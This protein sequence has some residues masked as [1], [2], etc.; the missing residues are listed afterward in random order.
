MNSFFSV[1]QWF[2]LVWHGRFA[3]LLI[4]LGVVV[5]SWVSETEATSAW[6]GTAA[7]RAL[8]LIGMPFAAARQVLFDSY[9]HVVLRERLSQPVTLVEID[10][11]SLK[12]IGQWPWPRNQLAVLIDMIAAQKPLAIGLDFY[13]P[14]LD[15]TSPGRV[16]D[17]L[18][19][20]H[21][22]LARRLRQLPSHEA[23]LVQSLKAA[24]T[25]LG[26]AGLDQETPI[27]RSG[28]RAVP[29]RV[30]GGD[31]LPYL[32][33][34]PWVLAS[35]PEL[36]AAARGQALLSIDAG[37]TVIRRMPLVMAVNSQVLPS[38]ALEMLRVATAEP[39]LQ[40]TVDAHG[41]NSITV[42]DLRIPTQAR[43]D[44]WLHFARR[45]DDDLARQVSAAAVMQGRLPAD[46]LL[47]KLVLVGLTGAGLNDK[48]FTP[49]GQ[50]VPGIELQA[51]LLETAL[52][53]RFLLRPWWLKG[54][55]MGL[56]VIIGLLMVWLIPGQRRA[57]SSA[58]MTRLRQAPGWLFLAGCMAWLLTG[59][60][61]F[62]HWGWLMDASA[63]LL[64]YA[65]VLPSLMFSVMLKT[66]HDNQRLAVIQQQLREDAARVTGEL[67]VAR[68]IQLGSL[69]DAAR[70]FP[71]EHRFELATLLEPA[72]EVGGDLFD[73]FM[74]DEHR[75][76]FVVADVSGKG[77]PASLFMAVT[78]TLT[79]SFSLRLPGG[80]A[81][82]VMA[83]NQDL[84][85]E[86]VGMLFVTLL[87]GV[88]DVQSGALELVNAG[89]DAPWRLSRLGSVEKIATPLNTGGP[90]LCVVDDFVYL[91]Q[92]LQLEPGDTL[93]LITDGVTE[94]M[95][96]AGELFG[97]DR[98]R[99]ALAATATEPD[100]GRMIERVRADIAGFVGAAQASDDLTLLLLR[101]NPAEAAV[102]A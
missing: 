22:G 28:L 40:V 3:A 38:L 89:H 76:C 88:L 99:T 23:R 31:A 71:D 16:A 82:V 36:Q 61:L 14:E 75:L 49:L 41:I 20:G 53:G 65:L 27:T 90:P 18:P 17:N 57:T 60:V 66:E 68:H 72:R 45:H 83:A 42:A 96:E 46:A 51:Q 48:R 29:V 39:T 69:P 13:M 7:G 81:E 12:S 19:V 50:L 94:A 2:F 44:V 11:S 73:F 64:G 100:L 59:F 4:L 24:P 85:R 6:Q 87:L 70:A 9:Q 92:H 58:L 26:A 93:C 35:L 97:S 62:A 84:S 78:K 15:Q 8:G 77:V 52:E 54:V 34:Y 67:A 98:L 79:K 37:Q 10:E 91:P 30:S 5:A 95:N 74:I 102:G 80:P 1:L 63:V 25:V 43:G 32:M 33:H 86:N 47:D 101:W 21:E 55:E 56:L